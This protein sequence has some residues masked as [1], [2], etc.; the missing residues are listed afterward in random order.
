MLEVSQYLTSK[1]YR[2]I[3]IK[4]VWYWHK[5]RYEDQWNRIQDPDMNPRSYAHLIFGKVNKNI[6]WRIDS[7]FN[8][9]FWEKVVIC[10]QKTEIRSMPII[11]Y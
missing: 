2:A 8:K 1:Y 6:R 7:L 3:A 9:C 4:T 11:L 5:N 10:L